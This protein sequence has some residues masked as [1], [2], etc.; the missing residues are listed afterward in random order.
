[1]TVI[2][3]LCN[4]Y[5]VLCMGLLLLD[6]IYCR[7]TRCWVACRFKWKIIHWWEPTTIV[8]CIPDKFRILYYCSSFPAPLF[9]NLLQFHSFCYPEE[10]F[11]HFE[12]RF[13]R[14]VLSERGEISVWLR[15]WPMGSD[16]IFD[17]IHVVTDFCSLKA[18]HSSFRSAYDVW[19]YAGKF[20]M[21]IT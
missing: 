21:N 1:M 2:S 20:I 9:L 8:I 10:I 17:S 19:S 12:T 15:P 13:R 7:Q 5:M 18:N 6:V 11:R 3:L 14:A 16:V 4:L